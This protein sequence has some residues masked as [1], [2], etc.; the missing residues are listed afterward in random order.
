MSPKSPP[1]FL[2]CP[3]CKRSRFG[4][5]QALNIHIGLI[6]FEDSKVNAVSVLSL[7]LGS[8]KAETLSSVLRFGPRT[9]HPSQATHGASS[10]P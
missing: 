10:F 4:S 5:L 1:A 6:H 2:A 3:Y 9:P 8:E 7:V